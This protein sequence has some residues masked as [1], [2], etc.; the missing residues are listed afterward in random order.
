MWT[1]LLEAIYGRGGSAYGT[2]TKGPRGVKPL[3][4]V[5][6]AG[7]LDVA[8]LI[9]FAQRA[10]F[11]KALEIMRLMLPDS[12]ESAELRARLET[13]V[14]T[15]KCRSPGTREEYR[16]HFN[17]LMRSRLL[18]VATGARWISSYFS[19][20]K[21]DE[22]DR[23]IFNGRLF[24]AC[25]PVSPPC[26]I[27]DIAD[28]IDRIRAMSIQEKKLHIVMGD[29][30]HWFHQIAAPQ[31]LREFFGLRMGKQIFQW[32]SLPMGWSWS[33]TI[34]QSFAWAVCLFR[35][36]SEKA[37][38]NEDDI[39][40]PHQLPT[41][42]RSQAG[43][44]LSVYYDNFILVTGDAN[45]AE[46][47]EARMRRAQRRTGTVIKPGSLQYFRPDSLEKE[48]LTCLGVHLTWQRT[49]A[50]KYSK[51]FARPAKLARWMEETDVNGARTL[52]DVAEILG[53]GVY[54]LSIAR[55]LH[56]LCPFEE[57][58]RRLA[59]TVGRQA[60]DVGWSAAAQ[61]SKT[62]WESLQNLWNS[63]GRMAE[64][65]LSS[66]LIPVS[67]E[68]QWLVATDASNDGFGV[69]LYN[70]VTSEDGQPLWKRVKMISGSWD[71]K[72]RNAIIYVKELLAAEMGVAMMK[73]LRGEKW[74]MVDNAAAA[75]ALHKRITL[76]KQGAAIIQRMDLSNVRVILVISEDNPADCPSRNDYAEL[77]T[78]EERISPI[79]SKAAQ[80]NRWSSGP[81]RDFK[82]SEDSVCVLRHLVNVADFEKMTK[83]NDE[84]D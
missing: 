46:A 67:L 22:Y 79:M 24:S 16:N 63:V 38:F 60:S 14:R 4:P 17:E 23:S 57:D 43:G 27:P 26:N 75:W 68:G 31:Y 59:S 84:G 47:F 80:G 11:G 33:P 18:A 13:S 34:A 64:Q 5:E 29:F 3:D 45:E 78:R 48:G 6:V 21:D 62:D 54:C 74:L 41:F 52:R 40:H 37:I 28:L 1:A 61:L 32:Q 66:D 81:A 65:P 25:C 56:A 39:A 76:N 50:G 20:P 35:E 10:R 82:G 15:A 49:S 58:L 19:V 30:R 7:C 44:F 42:V 72:D 2:Y 69:I 51:I 77:E 70:R 12:V 53:R 36:A 83:E 9:K 73:D 71:E 55:G 8:T